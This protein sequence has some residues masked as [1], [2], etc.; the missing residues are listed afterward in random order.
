MLY[1]KDDIDLNEC[2]F[3]GLPMYLPP[4]GQNKTYKRVL[5]K[6]MFYLP[7]MP[8]LQILYT[9]MESA[10]Q[11]RWNSEIRT[12]DDVLRYPSDRKAGKH[13]DNV[14]PEFITTSI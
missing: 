3:C 8:R 9:L 7:I 11:M 4:N 14:Y 5:I 1:Y 6:R 13:F 12:N 10:N 2:T